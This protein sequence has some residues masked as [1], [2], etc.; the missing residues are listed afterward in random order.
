MPYFLGGTGGAGKRLSSATHPSVHQN[1]F[2][3][4]RP[5]ESKRFY[6]RKA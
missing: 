5:L 6:K 2:I 4:R 3:N 1:R